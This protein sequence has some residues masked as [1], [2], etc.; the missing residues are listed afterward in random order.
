MGWFLWRRVNDTCLRFRAGYP[1]KTSSQG[2]F[3]ALF[4]VVT[5]KLIQVSS[6]HETESLATQ[7]FQVR[8]KTA[9]HPALCVKP[10][11]DSTGCILFH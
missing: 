6:N 9:S 2:R 11:E 3:I 4:L 1:L 8:Q 10:V 5:E 7:L